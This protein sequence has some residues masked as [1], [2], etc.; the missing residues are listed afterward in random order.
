MARRYSTVARLEDHPNLDEVLGGPW[1]S[2]PT[3]PTPTCPGWPRP[4]PTRWPSP[5]HAAGPCPPTAR[6]CA[7][8][9]AAF[10]AVGAL[11]ADD[12]LGEA[13]YLVV[14]ADVASTALKA[15]RD[16]IAAVYARPSW[17][18]VSTPR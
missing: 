10:E 3:S 9:L 8:C 1:R 12:L 13:P 18:A 2:S 15:V 11:F 5:R 7:R 17:P 4:G 16:A 14:E 6:W